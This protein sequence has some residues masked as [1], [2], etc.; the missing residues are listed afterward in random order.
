MKRLL[1]IMCASVLAAILCGCSSAAEDQE[2]SNA[3]EEPDSIEASIALGESEGVEAVSVEDFSSVVQ[4]DA[5][6]AIEEDASFEGETFES[7]G[8]DENALRVSGA[9]V[10]LLDVVVNKSA[11]SSSS[12]ENGDSYGLNAGLLAVNGAELTIEGSTILTSAQNGNGVFGFGS[13]TT[14]AISNSTISTMSDDSSGIRAAA[15]A[16]VVVSELAV[17][18]SGDSSPAIATGLG[19]GTVTVY[20]GSF[21]SKGSDSPAISSL[22]E[23]VAFN[24]TLTAQGSEAL[25]IEDGSS[26]SLTNCAVTSNFVLANGDGDGEDEE[27]SA[28]AVVIRGSSAE[29][30]AE[31]ADAG[32]SDEAET[33]EAET[34]E[35]AATFSMSGGSLTGSGSLIR[36][37]GV[38]CSI[39]LS[40]V[41]LSGNEE[42]STLLEVVGVD[43]GSSLAEGAE[44]EGA[45][46][47]LVAEAQVLVGD[48]TV[49]DVSTL[50]LVLAEGSSFTGTVNIVD[51][52]TGAEAVEGN[53]SVV[54]EE[55]CTWILTGDCSLSSLTNNGSIDYNG[56]SITMADGTV[57][58]A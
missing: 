31:E 19:G 48:V 55:G 56:Y 42:G 20:G 32:G 23:V 47:E 1:P 51:S 12:V 58:S 44:A 5:A 27:E 2:G 46:V 16:S 33:A 35:E 13:G 54:V 6:N 52:E 30:D 28:S 14:I 11:G 40:D 3:V 8:D 18:T 4:G 24:A 38:V 49:D 37:E 21:V 15:G 25:L 41:D 43:L 9:V 7:T 10:S 50:S 45:Q 29:D 36:V 34:A 22:S 53:A 57:L 17:E 26:I 39:E